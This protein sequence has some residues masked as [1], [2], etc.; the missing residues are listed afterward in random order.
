MNQFISTSALHRLVRES[1]DLA[2]PPTSHPIFA[3]NHFLSRRSYSCPSTAGGSDSMDQS[4][5][6]A[7]VVNKCRTGGLVEANDRLFY[8]ERTTRVK[9][10]AF[11]SLFRP[12]L[13]GWGQD[14]A[15]R[16]HH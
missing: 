1:G 3:S 7:F 5:L 2:R 9:P 8:S 15:L 11:T 14:E 16:H 12:T 6:V 13:G 10:F 4:E